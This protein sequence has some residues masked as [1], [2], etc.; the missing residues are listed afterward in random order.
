M[1]FPVRKCCSAQE[2]QR[3]CS[4]YSDA[5]RKKQIFLLLMKLHPF[6]LKQLCPNLLGHFHKDFF[7]LM[8]ICSKPVT[9]IFKEEVLVLMHWTAVL[10]KMKLGSSLPEMRPLWLSELQKCWQQSNDHPMCETVSFHSALLTILCKNIVCWG[11]LNFDVPC[12]VQLFLPNV[13]VVVTR[14]EVPLQLHTAAEGI[15]S[16]IFHCHSSN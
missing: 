8:G 9:R 11:L 12:G 16:K 2:S 13:T 1:L 10:A 6:S 14:A 4:H 3:H 15:R 7:F 5:P